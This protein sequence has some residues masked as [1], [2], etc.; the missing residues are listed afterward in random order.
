MLEPTAEGKGLPRAL[1]P[2]QSPEGQFSHTG[3]KPTLWPGGKRGDLSMS[4]MSPGYGHGCGKACAWSCHIHCLS[5]SVSPYLCLS[6]SISISP[7][8]CLFPSLPLWLSLSLPHPVLPPYM[9]IF[10]RSLTILV[11][12]PGAC[13][14]SHSWPTRRR[15]TD[16]PRSWWSGPS[17]W[18]VVRS[19]GT[20]PC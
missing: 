1:P 7:R 19:F 14:F 18:G 17:A 12:K 9:Y 3:L 20:A 11:Q 10:F 8:L 5:V 2:V 15:T 16:K 6:V 13:T 4:E